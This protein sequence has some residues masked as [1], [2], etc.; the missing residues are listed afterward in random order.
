L[1]VDP[2]FSLNKFANNQIYWTA[3][4]ALSAWLAT[5]PGFAHRIG[6][7]LAWTIMIVGAIAI[8]EFRV[9]AVV[10]LPYLP[11]WLQADDHVLEI[12]GS[13]NGRLG[14]GEYRV[15]GTFA[16][17]LY[18][19][20]YLAITLPFAVHMLFQT[21]R[22]WKFCLAALGVMAT[23]VAMY[24]TGSRSA[25]LAMVLTPLL[26][27]FMVSWRLR[28]QQPSSL[29]A[30]AVLFAYPA[31]VVFVSALVVFWR[32]LH[33]MIIGGGQHQASTDARATQW[34]S[35]WPKVLSHPFGHGGGNSGEVLGFFNPGGDLP[36]V[37]S[38]FLTLLLDYGFIG[39]VSFLTLMFASIW[40]GFQG[41]NR[42]REPE[43]KILAPIT[44]AIF[45]FTIIKAVSSTEGSMP[46][47]FILIGCIIGL[48][49]QQQRAGRIADAAVP[50][51]N[52]VALA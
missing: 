40:Y 37:D 11:T 50:G 7:M 8:N 5:S 38:Y 46:I 26:Y 30:S 28:K 35:G 6:R 27:G 47:I 1:S 42:A 18:F 34:A 20:E 9:S 17:A 24:F 15:R 48:T 19:A 12:V 4:L 44:I 39:L 45:N 16:G 32:R 52:K 2:L 23:L 49:A 31:M 25:A 33:V 10:W 22:L 29:A 41:Y 36:T 51:R 14:T 43:M 13:H 3:M 21:D